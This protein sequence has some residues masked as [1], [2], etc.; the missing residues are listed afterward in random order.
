MQFKWGETHSKGVFKHIFFWVARSNAYG[1]T[2][3][4][5]AEVG[6]KEDPFLGDCDGSSG[7]HGL[8]YAYLTNLP[9]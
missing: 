6:Q 1:E 4:A 8:E 2:S 7:G 5:T 3:Y 9:L